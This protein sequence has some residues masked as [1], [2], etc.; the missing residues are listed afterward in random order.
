MNDSKDYPDRAHL[1]KFIRH[2]TGKSERSAASI[3]ERVITGAH[4]AI[5]QAKCCAER[6]PDVEEFAEKLVAIMKRGIGRLEQR[7]PNQ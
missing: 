3:I 4:A 7:N 1:I 5:G 2:V 6:H